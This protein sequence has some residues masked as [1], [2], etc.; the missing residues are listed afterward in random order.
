MHGHGFSYNITWKQ[1]T[2]VITSSLILVESSKYIKEEDSVICELRTYHVLPGKMA[3]YS[4]VFGEFVM[5]V[6]KKLG[7]NV[8]GVWQTVIGESNEFTY[9]LGFND[10][11]DRE[12]KFKALATEP[13]MVP[14]RQQPTRVSHITNKILSPQPY[15][16]MK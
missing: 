6:L 15:S 2:D 4:K 1:V 14:Y 12:A 7:F 16:P 11:A 9:M 8:I 13:D 3:E 5:P 10:L